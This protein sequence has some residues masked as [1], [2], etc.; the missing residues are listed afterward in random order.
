M[1]L[2]SVNLNGVLTVQCSNKEL[3]IL[4]WESG[5]WD[6]PHDLTASSTGMALSACMFAHVKQV[7]ATLLP[8]QQR[9]CLC[10]QLIPLNNVTL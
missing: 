6:I 7:R 10:G 2:F 1:Q 5:E 9:N 8:G 3:S 4:G